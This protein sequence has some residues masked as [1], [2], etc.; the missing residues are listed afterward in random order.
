MKLIAI[1]LSLMAYQYAD[2]PLVV[3]GV[4]LENPANPYYG[5]NL[6]KGG[7]LYRMIIYKPYLDGNIY[8][9]PGLSIKV[10]E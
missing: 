8:R 9:M 5:Y 6:R 3:W 1:A 7:A 10:Q 2:N 4:D